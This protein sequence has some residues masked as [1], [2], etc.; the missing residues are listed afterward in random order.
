MHD[1]I[2]VVF[3]IFELDYQCAGVLTCIVTVFLLLAV[4]EE[5]LD[6][7]GEFA[8]V[9]SIHDANAVFDVLGVEVGC[10]YFL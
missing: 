6:F 10:E 3:E 1:S 4:K 5:G 8:A 9:I 2:Q 7:V